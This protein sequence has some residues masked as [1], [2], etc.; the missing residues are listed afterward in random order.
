MNF[1]FLS[2]SELTE[3][4]YDANLRHS[5]KFNTGWDQSF[6]SSLPESQGSNDKAKRHKKILCEGD[7]VLNEGIKASESKKGLNRIKTDE[8]FTI[9]ISY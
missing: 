7:S 2:A 6:H 9:H 5:Y 8:S 3:D 4:I 1:I